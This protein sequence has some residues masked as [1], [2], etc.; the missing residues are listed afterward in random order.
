MGLGPVTNVK[1]VTNDIDGNVQLGSPP[2]NY[3]EFSVTGDQTFIGSAGLS[4]GEISVKDNSTGDTV[5]TTK[6]QFTRFDTNGES[7]NTTPNHANDHITINKAG[8]YLITVSMTVRSA[9]AQ[10]LEL[11]V[12]CWK[13]DGDAEIENVHSH[14]S[15]AGGVTTLGSMSLSGIH[16]FSA[17]D[18]LELWIEGQASRD[19]VLSDV[20]MTAVQVGG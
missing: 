7:N 5:D 4:Y 14:R 11:D 13:N 3:T 1:N 9:D 2:D 8:R 18:T 17:N 15:F 16:N 6:I 12:S 19:M 10:S 20:T